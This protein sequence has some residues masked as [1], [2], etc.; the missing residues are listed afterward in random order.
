VFASLAAQ[1]APGTV[2]QLTHQL[3]AE[4]DATGTPAGQLNLQFA[5]SKG[6]CF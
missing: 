4:A 2:S 1:S 3:Q 6:N 5:Q